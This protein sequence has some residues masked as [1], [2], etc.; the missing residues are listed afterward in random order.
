VGF[1]GSEEEVIASVGRLADAG[2]TDF[3]A[4]IIGNKEESERT[5]SLVSELART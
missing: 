2:A 5:F 4:L 3:V 1:I